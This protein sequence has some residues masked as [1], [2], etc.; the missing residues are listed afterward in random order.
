MELKP[1]EIGKYYRVP[2]VRALLLGRFD[3]WPVL[4]PWHEDADFVGFNEEH[5]HLDA[6]FLSV[7]Q[8][9]LLCHK[10]PLGEINLFAVVITAYQ[11]AAA[12]SIRLRKC[13][14]QFP[15]QYPTE[16]AKWIPAL[17]DAFANKKV[18]PGLVCPHRGASLQGL[19]PDRD[20]CVTCPLHGLTW[21][22]K[23]GSLVR[24]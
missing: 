3:S 20:G 11:L 16:R 21:D 22:C 6:R 18:G 19:T 7:A 5:F 10:R 8:Y 2:C 23:T 15:E 14:R 1:Y 4:G 12:A 17:Q 9:R 24:H 13:K